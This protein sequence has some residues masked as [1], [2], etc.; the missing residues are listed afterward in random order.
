[1]SEGVKKI[2]SEGETVTIQIH[3]MKSIKMPFD[4]SILPFNKYYLMQHLDVFPKELLY[5]RW[6]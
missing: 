2:M 6:I 1:M 4:Y 3:Q 5:I